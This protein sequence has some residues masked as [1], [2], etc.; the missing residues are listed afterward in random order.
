MRS[1]L[2]F[3]A[4]IVLALGGCSSAESNHKPEANTGEVAVTIQPTPG[5]NEP[6]SNASPQA[7]PN[8]TPQE[9]PIQSDV[10]ANSAQP[11]QPEDSRSSD[12]INRIR[13]NRKETPGAPGREIVEANRSTREGPENSYFFTELGQIAVETRVFRNHPV[14]SK[15]EKLNDGTNQSIKIYL[16]DGH[17][18]GLPGRAIPSIFTA[19]SAEILAAAGIKSVSEDDNSEPDK[20]NGGIR[21]KEKNR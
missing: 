17:I 3:T 11:E 4:S 1:A 10:N 8:P 16:K 2:L 9:K 20:L 7:T 18:I 13:N 21:K 19:A 15:I 5:R 12:R 14:L 6:E